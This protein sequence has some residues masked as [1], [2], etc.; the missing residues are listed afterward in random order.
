MQ[1]TIGPGDAQRQREAIARLQGGAATVNSLP[2]VKTGLPPGGILGLLQGQSPQGLIGMLQRAAQPQPG[3]A[4]NP[5]TAPG[6]GMIGARN[7]PASNIADP[8]AVNPNDIVLG[9][10][11]GVP[12]PRPRPNLP[13]NINPM[14][15][16]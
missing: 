3:A 11:G 6:I 2:P 8:A 7:I 16:F 9:D 1:P 5:L 14:D 15:Q 10:P 4:P 12:M 13:M